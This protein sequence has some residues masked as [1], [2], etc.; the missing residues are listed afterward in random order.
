MFRAVDRVQVDFG[1]AYEED[2]EGI[3]EV[4]VFTLV[5]AGG[6]DGEAPG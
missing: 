1:L 3:E 6:N 2:P 4:E 5:P